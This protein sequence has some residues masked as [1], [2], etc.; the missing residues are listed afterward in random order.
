[1]ERHVVTTQLS[2]ELTGL[3][4]FTLYSVWVVAHNSNGAGTT[5]L[6]LSVQTLSDKPSEAPANVT[7]EPSGATVSILPRIDIK[8]IEVWRSNE[9]H[10][11]DV[12]SKFVVLLYQKYCKED[13]FSF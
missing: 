2:Y 13:D 9:R 7:L 6:E 10:F 12:A 5:S 3:S 4:H 1:M 11:R 8:G